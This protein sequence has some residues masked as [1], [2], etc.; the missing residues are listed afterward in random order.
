MSINIFHEQLTLRSAEGDV[1]VVGLAD[2]NREMTELLGETAAA[3]NSDD[4]VAAQELD[5]TEMESGQDVSPELLFI[6][7][8]ESVSSVELI[9]E[10]AP[11]A[12]QSVE[13]PP[14]A[15]SDSAS[16]A[17]DDKASRR[18]RG[19]RGGR[20]GRGSDSGER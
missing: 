19:R 4:A 3:P 12:P 2:F 7:E 1:R 10:E 16:G 13:P 20:R 8:H 17:T 9:L 11:G 18:R 14:E 6:F 15:G 5:D